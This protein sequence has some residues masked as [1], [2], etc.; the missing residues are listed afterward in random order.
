MWA[1][2]SIGAAFFQTARN[3]LSRHVTGHASP[4]LISWSRFAFNLPFATLLWIVVGSRFGW[5]QTDGAFWGWVTATALTQLVAN[6]ALIAAFSRA[7]FAQAIVLHKLEVVLAA[8][9]GV[10]LFG[11]RPSA[12]GWLGILL[13][14]LGTLAI[15]LVREAPGAAAGMSS[16][17]RASF[18]LRAVT[19]DRGSWLS[20]LSGVLLVITGFTLKEAT[21]SLWASNPE[22]SGR[23]FVSA[24]HVL[25]HTV[26]IEV[27]V[28]GLALLVYDRPELHKVRRL[29]PRLVPIGAAAFAA[30]LLWFWAYPLTLVAYVKAVGQVEGILS[31]V[32]ALWL[33]RERQVWR[34][35][36]GMLLILVGIALVL[37][38]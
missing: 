17:R 11:E 15:N 31:V 29:L 33:W 10:A 8:L 38:G 32:L 26:W 37:L 1:W 36:P 13:C 24:C 16:E 18:A 5:P 12:L 14:A 28:L 25:F 34:Q 6:V 19:F 2:L 21:R 3:A 9:V 22:L 30:S 4:L 23:G 7:T 27:A 20:L 35:L